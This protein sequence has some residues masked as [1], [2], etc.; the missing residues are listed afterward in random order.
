MTG[1]SFDLSAAYAQKQ[2][3]LLSK[4]GAAAIVS[5]P[6]SKGDISE[7][8]WLGLLESLLPKRYEVSQATVVDCRGGQSDSIDV[9]IHDGHFSP[10]VFWHENVKYIPAESVYAVFECKPELSKG[11]LEYA[12][13][14]AESV[15]KLHRTSAPIVHAAGKILDPKDPPEI[16]AGLLAT[17]SDWTPP[18]GESFD[19]HLLVE[20]AGRLDLGCAVT[21]GAWEVPTDRTLSTVKTSADKSLVFFAMR[22]LA[23]LQAMGTI[24]AM[25]YNAWTKSLFT[26]DPGEP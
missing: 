16:L 18:L 26:A 8:S 19:E 12:S 10:L 1:P 13:K 22:L 7:R 5:H 3:E 24:P 11:R 9:V 25:D 15:R 21:G 17:R 6:D 14:K 23:R 2:D 4:L 20:G